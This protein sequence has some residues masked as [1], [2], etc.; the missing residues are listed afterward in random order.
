MKEI[1]KYA[2]TAVK[3]GAYAYVILETLEFFV[4]K[5]EAVEALK[6]TVSEQKTKVDEHTDE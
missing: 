6:T 4:N 1:L 3:Y 5:L 2:K